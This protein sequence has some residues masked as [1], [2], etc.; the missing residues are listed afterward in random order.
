MACAAPVGD[1]VE[2][3]GL[4][5]GCGEPLGGLDGSPADQPGALFGDGAAAHGGVRLVVTR[6]EPSPGAQL[7]RAGEAMQVADL[8]HQ[9][10]CQH[11]AYAGDGLDCQVTDITGQ[12]SG[13]LAL[14]GRDLLVI[15]TISDRSEAIRTS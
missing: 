6:R 7:G 13:D 3:G 15:G 9:H 12:P 2:V 4:L 1:A 14:Q 8:G 5:A 10:R 11:R